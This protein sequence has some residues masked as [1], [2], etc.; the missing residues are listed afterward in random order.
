L[1]IRL[2][3]RLPL[4]LFFGASSLLLAGMAVVFAGQG[5]AA[6]QEAGK[7]PMDPLDFHAI[8]LLGIYPNLQG[9]GLQFALVLLIVSGWFL[10]REQ[11]RRT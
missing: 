1:I 9:I 2:S 10:M 5:I 6:L 3:V 7:L 11:S 8:P 4:G